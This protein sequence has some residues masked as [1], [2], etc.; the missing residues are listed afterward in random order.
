MD[1]LKTCPFCGGEAKVYTTTTG[2][3]PNLCKAW[4][5]CK[6]CYSSAQSYDDT[7]TNGEFV[8]KAI[9]ALNRRVSDSTLDGMEE[10]NE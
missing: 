4:C 8:F 9:A 3:L 1:E 7:D 2:G 10:H 6:K 5:Y